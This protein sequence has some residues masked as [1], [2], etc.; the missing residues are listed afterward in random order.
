[1]IKIVLCCF[2]TTEKIKSSYY[3]QIFHTSKH[4][5]FK[6]NNE[7]QYYKSTKKCRSATVILNLSINLQKKKH[8]KVF[9]II[10]LTHLSVVPTLVE[11]V[12]LI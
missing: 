11:H 8:K 2:K 3:S 6:Y 5:L 10:V 7:N 4:L 12:F 9:L 1:M